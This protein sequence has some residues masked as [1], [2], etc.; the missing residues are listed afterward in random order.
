MK[1]KG[2][3]LCGLV[4]SMSGCA[5]YPTGAQALFTKVTIRLRVSGKINT[6]A[7][8][9]PTTSYIYVIAIR[10]STEANPL[11]NLAPFPAINNT[12]PNGRVSGSPTHFVEFN[13]L[14]PNASFPFVLYNFAPGP[15][16]DDPT[17]PTDLSRFSDT[18]PTRGPIVSFVQYIPGTNEIKFD[19][20]T[21]QLVDSDA[22][23]QTLQTL[24]VNLLTMNR[25][26]NQGSGLRAWDAI[27]DNRV[28]GGLSFITVDLRRNGTVNNS[29][30]SIEPESDVSGANDP[31]LDIVDWSVDV[32]RP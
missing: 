5:K 20:F 1:L 11:P 12:N 2:L 10:A 13:T 18:T 16:A 14:N 8:T 19:V 22:L 31:D 21:N 28:S 3:F 27:G 6:A 25:Y 15:T 26:T 7:D 30:L 29:F 9:D 4:L 17:N 24:Q 23:A 32:Q